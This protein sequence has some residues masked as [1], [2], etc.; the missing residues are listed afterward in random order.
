MYSDATLTTLRNAISIVE[1]IG[2][3]LPLKKSGLGYVGLCPFHNEK[4]PSFHVHPLKQCF[5]CFG[6]QKG[7][8]IFTF[9]CAIEGLSFPEAVKKLAKRAGIELKEEANS[10]R[11]PAPQP[12]PGLA[13]LTEAL[14]WATKYFNYLLTEVPEYR[15]ALDY[16]MSR[17]ISRKT[18]DRFRIGVSPRG[19]NTLMDLMEKRKFTFS[20]LTEAG[21][22]IAKEGS[23][24][25][26]YDRFRER[27]MFPIRDAEGSV[28]GFG[29]RL[30]NDEPNQPKYLN[31]P[32]SPLFSKRRC[33]YGIHES[34]RGIRVRGEAVIVEGYMDVVGLAECGVNNALA[35]MG[36]ALT[37]D[38]CAQLKKLCNRVVTVF[39]PDAGGQDAWRRSVHLFLESGIF[40]KDLSLPDGQDPDEYLQKEGAEKFYQ[41]CEKA[42]RQITKLLKEIATEGHLSEEESAKWLSEL[43]PILVASRRLSDRAILWDNISLVLKTSVEALKEISESGQARLAPKIE[44][45]PDAKNAPAPG[46]KLPPTKEAAIDPLD[47]DFFD[48]ALQWPQAFFAI[49]TT[50]WMAGIKEERVRYWLTALSEAGA[51]APDRWPP[52]LE[53]LVQTEALMKLQA[54][55]AK[56][57]IASSSSEERQ[58]KDA[59]LD[60]RTLRVL[61]DRLLKRKR[62]LEIRALSAQV[63]L[64]DKLGDDREGIR[65]LEKLKE[66]RSH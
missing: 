12:I 18:I 28:I 26:G 35:T 23:P 59:S 50:D 56:W 63:K 27:L 19:W 34:M 7:G 66:L 38:H 47:L 32:E 17:G 14:E 40:A 9:V 44:K 64:S 13:R 62:E 22:V 30:L 21:L 31:S 46:K 53:Q 5:H 10:R 29:A 25:K 2:E 33:F 49:P 42:P 39:D 16:L 1:L 4:T 37:E 3:Y 48:S 6:C 60:G 15:L 51:P 57:L 61:A 52:V 65:L 20:E 55:A 8:N 36:T 43:T 11:A 45:A 54:L 41:S 58:A 24:R